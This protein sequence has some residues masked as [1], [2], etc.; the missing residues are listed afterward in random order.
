MLFHHVITEEQCCSNKMGKYENSQS[1][2][3]K[4]AG[5]FSCLMPAYKEQPAPSFSCAAFEILKPVFPSQEHWQSLRRL[6]VPL[7][8]LTPQ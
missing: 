7:T 1:T 8:V 2:C 3:Q 5:V 4:K 6:H